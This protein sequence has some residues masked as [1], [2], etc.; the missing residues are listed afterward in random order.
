MMDWLQKKIAA[1]QALTSEQRVRNEMSHTYGVVD[2]C[3]RCF[4]CEIL[5]TNGWKEYCCGH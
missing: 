4:D 1:E 5:P 2:D 3:I